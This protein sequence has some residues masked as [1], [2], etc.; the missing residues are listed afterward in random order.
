MVKMV[1]M[2]KKVDGWSETVMRRNVV[3]MIK[4]SNAGQIMVKKS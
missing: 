2:V 4:R 1:K 3:K